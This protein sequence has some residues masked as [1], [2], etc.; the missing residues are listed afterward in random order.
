MT[1]P[2]RKGRKT[3]EEE[4]QDYLRSIGKELDQLPDIDLEIPDNPEEL[5]EAFTEQLYRQMKLG[6]LKSTALVNGLRAIASLADKWKQENPPEI[7]V[8]ERGIDEVLK[9]V[10]LPRE[11]RIEIGRDEIERLRKQTSD[12][13]LVVARIEGEV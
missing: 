2:K 13:E 8:D 3:A 7:T 1:E 5:L 4:V 9:D 6:E 12:L 11:R 10:G